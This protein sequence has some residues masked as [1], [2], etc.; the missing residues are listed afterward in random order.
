MQAR[1]NRPRTVAAMIEILQCLGTE[2]GIEKGKAFQPKKTDIIITPYG[3]SGTTWLQQMVHS[4]RTRGD[5]NFRE[6]TEV[7]PW[8]EMAYD[9]GLEIEGRQQW[10]PR[11]YKS[12]LSW[13]EVP[14]GGKYIYSFRNPKDVVV[15]YYHFFE[16]WLFESGA[17]SLGEFAEEFFL[18]REPPNRY[19]Y[20]IA[21]WWEQRENPDVLLL[22]FEEMKL[23]LP[24][25]VR[26]VAAFIGVEMD[27]ELFEIA[28]RHSSYEFMKAHQD[29]FDDYLMRELS[30]QT[31][32][33]PSGGN[34]LKVRA[35][36]ANAHKI[37]L[38]KDVGAVMDEI[39]EQ[40]I[41][42]KFGLG[43]YEALR[44]ALKNKEL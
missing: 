15:S 27:D 5:M 36:K 21:S 31:C 12:H 3:K 2:A 11:A 14:K 35:G 4:L 25:A 29:Q 22:C 6:V 19:W 10:I 43:S 17:F 38:P 13:D 7:V 20:H 33:I 18:K 42:K 34:A 41:T 32:G 28:V 37:E 30:E 24:E 23:N 40:E 39:W 9:L 1:A 44:E 8:L 16:D 26:K